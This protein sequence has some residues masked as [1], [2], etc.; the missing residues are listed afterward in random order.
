M[1][2]RS[3]A[4]KSINVRCSEVP[5]LWSRFEFRRYG[6][7]GLVTV[8]VLLLVLTVK[9]LDTSA[10]I[11]ACYDDPHVWLTNGTKLDIRTFTQAAPSELSSAA[12]TLYVPLGVSASKV[13]LTAQTPPS[14]ESVNVV[15]DQSSGYRVAAL[16]SSTGAGAYQVNLELHVTDQSSLWATASG[17]TNQNIEAAVDAD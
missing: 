7:A 1:K 10:H 17:S 6:R 15:Q 5:H 9:P 12:F 16:V 13:V 14:F 2:E 3:R 4:M 11:G 8:L